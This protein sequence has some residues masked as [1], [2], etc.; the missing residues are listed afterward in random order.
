MPAYADHRRLARPRE[1]AYALAAVLCVEL[2][3]GVGLLTGL[4]VSVGRPAEVVQRLLDF[5][6]PP[7]PPKPI[8][9]RTEPKRA[10]DAAEAPKAEPAPLGGSPGPKPAHAAPSVAP[11]VPLRP[12]VPP[13][14]GGAGTGPA[15]GSG[16]GG[17]TGGLGSGGSGRGG[18]DLELLSGDITPRDYPG[19]LA[20]AG[21]GG[22]VSMRGT[23]AVNGRVTGCRVTR[24]SGVP[25]LDML[26]CRLIEQRFVYRPATDRYGR[27]VP[28][29]IDIDWTWD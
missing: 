18:H 7:P 12:T 28:D 22:T 25:E 5:A 4:R 2:A 3:L 6:L 29:D 11:I 17:G 24:S 16:A 15:L 1:R 14:G 8:P 10:K 19:H 27:P 21:I 9:P 20:R 23:V 13:S 26:T